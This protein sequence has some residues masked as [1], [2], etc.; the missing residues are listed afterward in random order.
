[1]SASA[2]SDDY[3]E[4][5]WEALRQKRLMLPRCQECR[6]VA[7]PAG[8]VCPNCLSSNLVWEPGSGKGSIVAFVEYHHSFDPAIKLPLPYNVA[9]VRLEEGPTVIT[10]I[11]GA[12]FSELKNDMA[13]RAE[14]EELDKETTLLK[15]RLAGE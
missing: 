15:F 10:N 11:V 4:P 14:F 2:T 8:P 12:D 5:Y 6:F 7:L 13:V 1:M 3:S 9:L